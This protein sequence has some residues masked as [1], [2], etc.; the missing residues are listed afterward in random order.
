MGTRAFRSRRRSW[1]LNL[2]V[3]IPPR[4]SS[5]GLTL[6][7]TP[8]MR[9][10]ALCC[11]GRSRAGAPWDGFESSPASDPQALTRACQGLSPAAL[12]A[13]CRPCIHTLTAANI[14]KHDKGAK[15]G[16][17]E[18][19][20]IIFLKNMDL[21]L[22]W[23]SWPEGDSPPRGPPRASPAAALVYTC[24]PL[25]TQRLSA[26]RAMTR[27]FALALLEVRSLAC[28]EAEDTARRGGWAHDRTDAARKRRSPRSG[29]GRSAWRLRYSHVLCETQATGRLQTRNRGPETTGERLPCTSRPSPPTGPEHAAASR[30][31]A[32]EQSRM[33][34]RAGRLTRSSAAGAPTHP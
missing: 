11:P 17:S 25:K 2:R 29:I 20:A 18:G 34:T 6:V 8:R 16:Q 4:V 5:H 13:P 22:S 23:P 15:F 30:P 28:A 1:E 26:E 7:Q 24:S 27:S 33:R 32:S 21:L 19:E 10:S 3:T 14:S 9:S 12:R 31:H